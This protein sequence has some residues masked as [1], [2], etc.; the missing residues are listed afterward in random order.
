MICPRCQSANPDEHRYC[1]QCGVRLLEPSAVLAGS[2]REQLHRGLA[3]LVEGEW[4]RAREQFRRCLELD[5]RHGAS[6][7]YLGLVDCLEGAPSSGR[8]HLRRAVELDPD[9]VNGWLLLG[10]MAES[11]E[12]Y[13]EAETCLSRAAMLEPHAH[14][15]RARLAAL[16][17][18]RGDYEAALPELRRWVEAQPGESAPLLYLASSLVELE[19]WAEAA[20]VLDRAL[21]VEPQ[22]A[23]L[24]RRRGDLC[25]RVGE[26]ARAADHY[27]AALA[28]DSDDDETRLKHALLLADLERVDEALA[29]LTEVLRRDPESAAALYQ[30][31]LLR[32]TEKGDLGGALEDLE[33]ALELDPD[34]ALTR[35]IHQELLLERGSAPPTGDDSRGRA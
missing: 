2:L 12:D 21:A 25:R 28:L 11:E 26:K 24:H 22:S 6:A 17:V 15:A 4:G 7:L 18:A 31:G 32:Y 16:E 3:L 8:E 20:D 30:R 5:P 1:A 19:E 23:A 13:A 27:A 10:L 35:M 29:G 9:L 14:L 33:R 34:D